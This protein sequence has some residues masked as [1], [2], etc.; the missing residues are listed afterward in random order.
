MAYNIFMKCSHQNT[1]EEIYKSLYTLEEVIVSKDC[2]VLCRHLWNYKFHLIICSQ[3]TANDTGAQMSGWLQRRSRRSWKRLWFVLKEQVL[4]MYKAS[5]DVVALDGIPVLGYTVEPMKEV[6]LRVLR[7]KKNT[8]WHYSSFH[9]HMFHFIDIH[10]V[11]LSGAF[12]K[13]C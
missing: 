6:Y 3:V 12:T 1:D 5:E 4:Y 2:E 10:T 9:P 13:N 8:C 7:L 11:L